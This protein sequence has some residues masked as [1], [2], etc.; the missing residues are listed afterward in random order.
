MGALLA[1]VSRG[2]Q[3]VSISL[4]LLKLIGIHQGAILFSPDSPGS[5]AVPQPN[6]PSSVNGLCTQHEHQLPLAALLM[7]L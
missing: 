4:E 5:L 3:R 7:H 1:Q 6:S 2:A